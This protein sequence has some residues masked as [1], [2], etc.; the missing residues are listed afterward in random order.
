MRYPQRG[1]YGSCL[2]YVY[3]QFS[4]SSDIRDNEFAVQR[5]LQKG[6]NVW[7]LWQQ[8]NSG[9]VKKWGHALRLRISQGRQF[10]SY[11]N[12]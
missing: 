7:Y 10:G 11:G 4:K 3:K 5:G 2:P 9:F 8:S 1:L 6:F 12:F